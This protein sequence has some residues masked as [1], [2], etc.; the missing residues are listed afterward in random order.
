MWR[1]AALLAA[2]A[3]L[4]LA[5]GTVEGVVINSITRAPVPGATVDLRASGKSAYHAIAGASGAFRFTDVL[6]GEYTPS[7]DAD[8]F[9]V[10]QS[11]SFRITSA[12]ETVHV[13]GELDPATKLT[14]HVLDPDGKPI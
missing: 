2:A 13:Q 4:L 11:D 6:P 5:Q 7:F 1:W 3:P 12:G 10:F 9:F 8:R 14:G